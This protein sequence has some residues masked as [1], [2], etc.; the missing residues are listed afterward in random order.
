LSDTYASTG[1]AL[2]AVDRLK[3]IWGGDYLLSLRYAEYA[4]TGTLCE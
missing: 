3:Q 1:G 4:E 2:F